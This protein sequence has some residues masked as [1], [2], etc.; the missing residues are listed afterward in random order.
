MKRHLFFALAIGV[1]TA[2]SAAVEPVIN[3]NTRTFTVAS[4]TETYSTALSGAVDVVKDGPGRLVLDTAASGFTG[5]V[6]VKAGTLEIKDAGALGATSVP[7]SVEDGGRLLLSLPG[8]TAFGHVITIA[9]TG[10]DSAAPY[11]FDYNRTST[12]NSDSL[13]DGLVLADDATIVVRK[14]QRWGV[15]TGGIIELNGHTLTRKGGGEWMIKSIDVKS[16]GGAGTVVNTAGTLTFQGTPQVSSDVTFDI[17][18]GSGVVGLWAVEKTAGIEGPVHLAA[19][20]T[21]QAQ[22]GVNEGDN[23]VRSVHFAG[24]ATLATTFKTAAR[25]MTIDAVSGASDAAPTVDGIGSLYLTGDVALGDAGNFTAKGGY[26]Y[27]N[28]DDSERT[29]NLRI[30]S[31]NTTTIAGGD[32]FLCSLRVASGGATSGQLRHTGGVTGVRSGDLPR[33]GEA[34][35]QRA[36]FTMEGGEFRAS[37]TVFVAEKKGSFGAFRQTGGYFESWGPP[38][39]NTQYTVFLHIGRGGDALFVQTGGTNDIAHAVSTGSQSYR[40][41]MGSTNG[42]VAATIAGAG[43]E[44]RTSGF[45]MGGS[46]ISTNILNLA[47]GGTL[48]ANRFRSHN[49]RPAGSL[50]VVNVDGGIFAPTYAGDVTAAVSGT[51]PD[52]FVIWGGG[53]VVDTSDNSMHSGTG[54]TTLPFDFS[55]PSG[56]GVASIAL[57]SSVAEKYIGVGQVVIED[58]TG[59]G[60]SAY[61]E[62]DFKTKKLSEIVVTSRGCNYSDGAK[63]YLVSPDGKSRTECTLT[64]SSN[65]GLC[66]T[67]VK[68]GGPQL[69]LSGEAGSFSG[70][71]EVEEGSM[72]LRTEVSAVETLRV[73]SDATL[74]LYGKAVSPATKAVSTATFEGAG[75][76]VN[77]DVTVTGTLKAKCA[78]LFAGAHATFGGALT[79]AD[80]A[81]LEI[82]DPE[83]LATY[84]ESARAIAVSAAGGISG[85]PA[86]RLSGGAAVG[87]WTLEASPDGTSLLLGFPKAFVMV[88]R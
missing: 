8:S 47:N 69:I 5:T 17:A 48:K 75:S 15:A 18:S 39:G 62:F 45:Q 68:R 65:D 20:R 11:A 81:T 4:G 52:K 88:I 35:G 25:S 50:T 29:L 7:I 85:A 34:N 33:I 84:Q 32:T 72:Q 16:T 63:A 70:G 55:A 43:T 30:N 37:N 59:W 26:L 71:Y 40:A 46:G 78:E 23:R 6:V 27:F 77:G 10:A 38:T 83:N 56:S 31:T 2:A 14:D 87:N 76:V 79:F 28:G 54:T 86:L 64:L 67:L 80:G 57:P 12:G 74:D 58:A 73:E 9:G 22:A 42:T 41:L 19:G 13:I 61:A 82:S 44:F 53:M 60:A 24:S 66:G 51:N 1:A 21:L 49:S 3:G 36:Y